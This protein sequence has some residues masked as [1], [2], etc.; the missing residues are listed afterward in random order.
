MA[1]SN[2]T[3]SF[4]SEMPKLNVQKASANTGNEKNNA[5]S[6][7]KESVINESTVKE[8]PLPNSNEPALQT[9]KS[10]KKHSEEPRTEESY[11]EEPHT[12]KQAPAKETIQKS[13]VLT[14]N[15]SP[16]KEKE[17]VEDKDEP[18]NNNIPLR[19]DG[20]IDRRFNEN[21]QDKRYQM[22]LKQ[23]L[24][25]AVNELAFSM[26]SPKEKVS[27]NSL[28]IEA[29]EDLLIKYKNH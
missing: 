8:A 2:I 28:V 18:E 11:I 23:D 16:I 10:L 5:E 12:E 17:K 7:I 9:E 25:D 1:K 21:R 27:F 4:L 24:F 19:K 20:K 6:T 13:R 3:M 15:N 29:L 14:K 22:S 26:S